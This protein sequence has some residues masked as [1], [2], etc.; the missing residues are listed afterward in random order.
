MRSAPPSAPASAVAVP[1]APPRIPLAGRLLP[2]LLPLAILAGVAALIPVTFSIGIVNEAGV[3]LIAVLAALALQILTGLAGQLS[4]GSAALMAVGAFTVGVTARIAPGMPFP[5]LLVGAGLAGAAV[6][7]IVGVPAMRVRGFYLL[8]ATLALHYIVLF[9]L[10]GVQERGPGVVGYIIIRPS[11]FVDDIPWYYFV[12]AIT[13]VATLL[14]AGY[15]RSATGRAW[16]MMAQNEIAAEALGIDVR[17]MKVQAF[18]ISSFITSFAGG[19]VAYNIGVVNYESFPLSVAI[20]YIAAKIIAGLGSTSATWLG[21]AFVVWIP[22]F[23][24]RLLG[25]AGGAQNA[26]LNAQIGVLI[27]GVAIIAFMM[28]VPGG[29]HG[30]LAGLLRRAAAAGFVR[31]LGARAARRRG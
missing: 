10:Q 1:A 24:T 4:V 31:N 13:V 20:T 21:A 8:I 22:L 29:L 6:G 12:L 7:L 15:K 11:A 14:T 9:I 23:V 3:V 25:Q 2:E 5:V 18:V 30:V 26:N 27:F 28:F 19:L 16:L 17:A